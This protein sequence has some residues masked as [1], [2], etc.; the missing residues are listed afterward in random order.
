MA[1]FDVYRNP[2]ASARDFPYLLDIQHDMFDELPTR[3][4]VPLANP[5]VVRRVIHRLHPR[6]I[7][8]GREFVLLTPELAAIPRPL[9]P[10]VGRA[11]SASSEI[12]AALDFLFTAV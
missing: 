8:D 4:M 6:I 5:N 9:D 3:V 1:R 12:L 11:I 10:P 2:G 7:V